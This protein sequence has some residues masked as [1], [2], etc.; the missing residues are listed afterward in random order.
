VVPTQRQGRLGVKEEREQRR[1]NRPAVDVLV[2][3]GLPLPLLKAAVRTA[4][5]RRCAS[6]EQGTLEER[7]EREQEWIATLRRS[8][9]VIDAEA[10]NHEHYE[11]SP[12]FFRLVLGPHWKYSC[13]LWETGETSARLPAAE[14]RML[15]LCCERARIEDGQT[16]LDLGCGWG[17]FAVYVAERFPRA[18]VVA[19]SNA[20]SQIRIV[21]A[22]A[23]ALGLTNVEALRTNIGESS[24]TPERRFDR[25]VSVEFFEHVRNYA[26][27]LEKLG[28]WLKPDG[29]LFVHHF[30]HRCW[31]YPFVDRDASDWMARWFFSGG[32]MP[33]AGLLL[34]FQDDLVVRRRWLVD[35]RHYA[36]TARAW[37][38]RLERARARVEGTLG[39][40][41]EGRAWYHRWRLFFLACEELFGFRHGREWFIVHTLFSPRH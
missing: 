35:G 9:I 31:S 18:R 28:R 40:T 11:V 22:R 16:I 23:E 34:A 6:L 7:S 14:E 4:L 19:V 20:E 15:A 21:R 2:D 37:R 3:R 8:P 17:S 41:E 39:G 32:Q 38:H 33:A 29:R 25:I 1:T 12:D 5:R 27:L 36:R 30:A 24:W 10:A 26:A 13:G